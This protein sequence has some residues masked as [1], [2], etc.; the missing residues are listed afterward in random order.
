MTT[1]DYVVLAIVGLSI[2]VSVWRGA[3]REILALAS[4]VIAFVAAQAYAAALAGALPAALENQE[5]RM[6]AG[7]VG[8]F[9]L[10]FVL[11]TFASYLVAKLVRAAGL[12][13]VDRSLGAIFGL[14]RGMLVVV[15]LV[16]VGGLTSAPRDPAWRDAMLSPPLE[17]AAAVVK[18]FLPAE[19]ARRI[20]YE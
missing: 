9:V 7:F 6:L 17:A 20:S 5:L 15:T 14:L 8:V 3:V 1:F 2:I 4:W 12:G 18:T 11:A 19:L 13:P 16:L 10:V